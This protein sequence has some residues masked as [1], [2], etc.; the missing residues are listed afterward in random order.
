MFRIEGIEDILKTPCVS[1]GYGEE[2]GF[3]WKS[4]CIILDAFIHELSDYPGICARV[5]YFSL[6]ISTLVVYLIE[7]LALRYQ[8]PLD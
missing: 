6:E 2:N 1:F 8:F 5:G 7:I 4:T 3:T